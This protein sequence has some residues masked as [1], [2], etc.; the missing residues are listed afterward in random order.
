[1]EVISNI[2]RLLGDDLHQTLKKDAR[3]SIA[4]S[5]F[6][7]YAYE[8]LMQELQKVKKVRFIF[9]SPTFI[10]DSHPKVQREFGSW[11]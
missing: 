9:I 3:V 4:A 7:I 5:C 2:D 1:M 10:T 6:S 8:A 11:V